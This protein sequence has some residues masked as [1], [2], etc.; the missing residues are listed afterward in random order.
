MGERRHRPEHMKFPPILRSKAAFSPC[1]TWRYTLIRVWD[2]EE[3]LVMFVGLNPSTADEV[4]NDP[5]V[6][7]CMGFAHDWGFGGLLMTN[8]FAFRATDPKVMKAH[9]D[10]VGPEN[11][12]Y[13]VQSAREAAIIVGAW[14][15]HGD[16]L[17]R[18]LL[19]KKL[20]YAEDLPV[21]NCLGKTREGQPKHPLYLRRDAE[22]TPYWRG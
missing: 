7:R 18:D 14:G 1:R 13:L 19:L 2:L 22:L 21:L 10:P 4:Q 12:R 6:R 15:N 17:N 3:P 9:P 8:I 16:H 11:D 20:W 5:T